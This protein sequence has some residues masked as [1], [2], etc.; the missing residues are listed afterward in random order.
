M[1][2]LPIHTYI[3][4]CLCLLEVHLMSLFPEVSH[5]FVRNVFLE[6]KVIEVVWIELNDE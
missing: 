6:R 4:I 2:P 5:F 3:Y 1:Q